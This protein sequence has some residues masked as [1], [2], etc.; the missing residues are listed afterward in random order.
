MIGCYGES[1][2]DKWKERRDDIRI[3]GDD[4]EESE[5]DNNDG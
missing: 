4:K 2:E 3:N 1:E 5:D